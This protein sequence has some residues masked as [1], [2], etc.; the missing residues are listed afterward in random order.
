MMRLVT[1]AETFFFSVL[2]IPTACNFLCDKDS[3]QHKTGSVLTH[4]KHR[5][6]HFVAKNTQKYALAKPDEEWC[7]VLHC[8][9]FC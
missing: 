5:I 9:I 3:A 1:V 6:T 4:L 8:L 7:I 2:L